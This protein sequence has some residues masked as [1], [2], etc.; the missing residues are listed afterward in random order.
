MS[1][2]KTA[3]ELNDPELGTKKAILDVRKNEETGEVEYLIATIEEVE[4]FLKAVRIFKKQ[5]QKEN[6]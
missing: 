5:K 3:K 2:W 6:T 4:N 1:S